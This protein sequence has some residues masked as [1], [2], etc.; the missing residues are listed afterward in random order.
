MYNVDIMF[1]SH[2]KEIYETYFDQLY[3]K[4]CVNKS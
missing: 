2:D 1:F 3:K 4:N